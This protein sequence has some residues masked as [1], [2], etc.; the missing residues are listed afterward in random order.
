MGVSSYHGKLVVTVEV[1]SYHGSEWLPRK[2][3][4]IMEVIVVTM[5]VS[6]YHGSQWLPWK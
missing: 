4:V 2:L 3:V 5:E 6:S 1:S